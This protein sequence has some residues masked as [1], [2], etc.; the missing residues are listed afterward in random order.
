MRLLI[1]EDYFAMRER[2]QEFLAPEH[3]V[4]G[5]FEDC[6]SLIRGVEQLQPEIVVLDISMPLM[7]G[8]S[9]AQCIRH[10][11]PEIK[12]IFVTQHAEQAYVE[13]ALLL[14][15][16]AYVLKRDLIA[17]LSSAIREATAGRTFLSPRLASR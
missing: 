5:T 12:I 6:E 2:I 9:A 7:G 17:D 16:S 11:W 4:L 3:D 8:F 1:A 13:R 10:N 15:A 14:G